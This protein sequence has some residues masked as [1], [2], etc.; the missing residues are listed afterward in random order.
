MRWFLCRLLR[1]ETPEIISLGGDLQELFLEKESLNSLVDNDEIKGLELEIE[2]VKSSKI[3]DQLSKEQFTISLK[4]LFLKFWN[5]LTNVNRALVE[6]AIFDL[7]IDLF[8]SNEHETSLSL[9]SKLRHVDCDIYYLDLLIL[10]NN[11]SLGNQKQA[12]LTL[13]ELR[14]SKKL[15]KILEKYA[16]TDWE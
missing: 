9:L 16:L 12:L 1:E 2:K 5:K 8:N 6:K 3:T 11:W 4:D 7:A 14:K 10:L 13:L 15:E